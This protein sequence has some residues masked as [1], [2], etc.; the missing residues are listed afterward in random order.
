MGSGGE[1]F[2]PRIDC[3]TRARASVA[4]ALY[5]ERGVELRRRGAG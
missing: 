1:G 3:R 4:Q 2:G 5:A